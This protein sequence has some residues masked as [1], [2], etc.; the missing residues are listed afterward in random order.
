MGRHC[1]VSGYYTHVHWH[2][3]I[4]NYYHYPPT[5]WLFSFLINKRI[6]KNARVFQEIK[7]WSNVAKILCKSH[8][9]GFF[10]KPHTSCHH[11]VLGSR[12]VVNVF[13]CCFKE[14]LFFNLLT[15]AF[16]FLKKEVASGNTLDR[17]SYPIVQNNL[18]EYLK[19]LPSQSLCII[20]VPLTEA[21][22][23]SW[24][25]I[26]KRFSLTELI[27][28]KIVQK[29]LNVNLKCLTSRQLLYHYFTCMWGSDCVK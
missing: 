14:Y 13:I 19:T 5:T 3:N 24:G 27:L 25:D 10:H 8:V 16:V 21:K 2:L 1:T 20:W 29:V 11:Q 4:F 7:M 28:L 23:P 22:D 9:Y 15:L 26:R 6:L 12:L 18:K 17:M